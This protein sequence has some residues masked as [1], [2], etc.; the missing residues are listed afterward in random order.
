M[1]ENDALD[2]RDVVCKGGKAKLGRQQAGL[3]VPELSLPRNLTR[4]DPV[5][6]RLTNEILLFPSSDAQFLISLGSMLRDIV[7]F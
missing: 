7:Q 6:D 2:F 5:L 1:L 3:Q 4:M